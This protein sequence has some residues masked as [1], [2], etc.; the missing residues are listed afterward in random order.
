VNVIYGAAN[1]LTATNNQFWSQTRQTGPGTADIAGGAESNDHFGAALA[2]GNF[3]GDARNGIPIDD[4]AIG[5]PGENP[6]STLSS[7]QAGAVNV[8]YGTINRLRATNSQFW[9]QNNSG[10]QGGREREDH[11]GAALAAGNFNGDARNGMPIDDLAIGVPGEDL[12][13]Q[14]GGTRTD[15]GAVNVIYGSATRLTVDNNQFLSQDTTGLAS[16]DEIAEGGDVFGS[17]LAAGDFDSDGRDDLAVGV[18]G[19]KVGG[20]SKAGAVNLFEGRTTGLFVPSPLALISQDSVN[21]PDDAEANDRFGQAVALA[22]FD[23]DGRDDLAIGVPFEDFTPSFDAS[24][25]PINLAHNTGAVNVIYGTAGNIPGT[26]SQLWHQDTLDVNGIETR[27]AAEDD[28][29]FG[30]AL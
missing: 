30:S 17:A 6:G 22:D 1:G 20:L 9:S 13:V 5:V 8:L 23:N 21:V 18:P 11:F 19:E 2:V 12:S 3:N 15:V 4:L 27:D 26:D 25:N 14:N 7:F 10:I 16:G 28:D 24:G 29:E